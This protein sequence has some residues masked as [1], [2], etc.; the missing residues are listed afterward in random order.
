[1]LENVKNFW[2]EFK[3]AIVAG[4]LALAYLI[5]IKR[6]KEHEKA[7][8]N[9]TILENVSRADTARARLRNPDAVRR[10]HDKYRRK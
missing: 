6:G 1:M 2:Q 4:A 5:G 7:R 3:V 10:L 8:Q 9:K